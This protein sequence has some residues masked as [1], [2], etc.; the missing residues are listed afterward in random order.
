MKRRK[1]FGDGGSAL[2]DAINGWAS[3]EEEATI[4]VPSE[5]EAATTAR[6]ASIANESAAAPVPAQRP[7]PPRGPDPRSIA[8]PPRGPDPRRVADPPRGFDPHGITYVADCD[9]TAELEH[10]IG[11]HLPSPAKGASL[12][13]GSILSHCR[14]RIDDIVEKCGGSK[15]AVFKIGIASQLI[16][17]YDSYVDEG[18]FTL[19]CIMCSKHLPLIEM[20]EAALIALYET[21]AGCQNLQSGGDGGLSKR[22]HYLRG[23]DPL[24]VQDPLFFTYC[25]AA[26]ADTLIRL[27]VPSAQLEERVR[28]KRI[29]AKRNF[30]E[31]QKA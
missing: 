19:V 24:R 17:R 26:R 27:G 11:V 15:L 4:G 3:E 20:L 18:Y 16:P 23:Q 29:A 13:T 12:T 1:L 28:L 30:A 7:D 2:F 25:A 8:D 21:H 5:G 14:R 6:S 31:A 22:R 9:F 10:G